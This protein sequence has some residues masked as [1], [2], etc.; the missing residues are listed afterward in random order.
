[1]RWGMFVLSGKNTHFFIFT[2]LLISISASAFAQFRPLP[3]NDNK[4][5]EEERQLILAQI[6]NTTAQA[7]NARAQA[8]WAR[9]QMKAR[10]N[11]KDDSWHK[12]TTDPAD[13]LG[14]AAAVCAMIIAFLLLLLSALNYKTALKMQRD[15]A[16]FDALRRLGDPGNPGIRCAAATAIAE[17]ASGNGKKSTYYETAKNHLNAVRDL[18]ENPI[19]KEH[20][21]KL[22]AGSF[23]A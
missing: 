17:M 1:M 12:F 11:S 9:T 22:L 21:S 15:A 7:E 23:I 6:D 4:L 3:R 2:V 8:A 13:A 19:V 10:I 18:E 20:I 5:S 14:A 16:F